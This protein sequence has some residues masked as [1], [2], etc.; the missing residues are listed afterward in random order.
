MK[1]SEVTDSESCFDLAEKYGVNSL[2]V[3]AHR[4]QIG[5]RALKTL[6]GLERFEVKFFF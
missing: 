5:F 4:Y 3:G 1:L 6:M 2:W